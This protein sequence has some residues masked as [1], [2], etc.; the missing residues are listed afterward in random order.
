MYLPVP[1][2]GSREGLSRSPSTRDRFV[3]HRSRRNTATSAAAS[4]EGTTTA[5]AST[6]AKAPNPF[7]ARRTHRKVRTGCKK[8][9]ER[10]IKV[11]C[12]HGQYTAPASLVSPKSTSWPLCPRLFPCTLSRPPLLY[13]V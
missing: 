2:S 7:G 8:C 13:C 12:L 11:R 1:G 10:K 6:S 4:D 9:K 5:S 3:P